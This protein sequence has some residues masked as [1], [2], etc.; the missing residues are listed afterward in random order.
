MTCKEDKIYSVPPIMSALGNYLSASYTLIFFYLLRSYHP[1]LSRRANARISRAK[2]YR[3]F[4]RVSKFLDT[5]TN[6]RK[7]PDLSVE[8]RS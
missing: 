7:I 5:T 8:S 3:S 6:Y 1:R 2:F 4:D